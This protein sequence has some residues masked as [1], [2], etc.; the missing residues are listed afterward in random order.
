MNSQAS[1][2]REGALKILESVTILRKDKSIIGEV[3]RN[4]QTDILLVIQMTVNG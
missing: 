3:K 2:C 1:L 4:F